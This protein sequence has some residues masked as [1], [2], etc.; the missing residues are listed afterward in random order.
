MGHGN[1]LF[2]SSHAEEKMNIMTW[3][4]DVFYMANLKQ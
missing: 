1:S 3:K 2:E 4:D